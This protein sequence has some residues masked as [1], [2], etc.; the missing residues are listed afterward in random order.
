[1]LLDEVEKMQVVS[2]DDLS[3]ELLDTDLSD[4]FNCD[5]EYDSS[6]YLQI[7]NDIE[8]YLSNNDIDIKEVANAIGLRYIKKDESGYLPAN[9]PYSV[10]DRTYEDKFLSD[11]YMDKITLSV[12]NAL[13][14]KVFLGTYDASISFYTADLYGHKVTLSYKPASD[15]DKKIID[16]YGNLFSTPSYLVRVKPVISIDENEVLEGGHRYLE[17]IQI[18]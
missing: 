6:N 9:L 15:E 17:H 8:N 18:L 1:M 14:G 5:I 4:L 16:K 10:V 13:Y 11:S 12:Q 7:Q 3:E 2:G